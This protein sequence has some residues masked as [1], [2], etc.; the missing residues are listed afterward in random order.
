MILIQGHL[1]CLAFTNKDIIATFIKLKGCFNNSTATNCILPANIKRAIKKAP[2]QF[3][4]DYVDMKLDDYIS[5]INAPTKDKPFGKTYTV[6]YLGNVAGGTPVIYLNL[7]I[8]DLKKVAIAQMKAGEAVWFG[9]DVQQWFL[10]TEG[11]LSM[12]IPILISR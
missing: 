7:P 6:K 8:E 3:F 1:K 12:N 9:S 11:L 5:L 10:K 4:A 2:Q